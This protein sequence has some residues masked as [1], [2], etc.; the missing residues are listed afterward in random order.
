MSEPT[1]YDGSRFAAETEVTIKFVV[2]PSTNAGDRL[3]T[4]D[5]VQHAPAAQTRAADL[6]HP[7]A[8]LHIMVSEA[9]PRDAWGPGSRSGFFCSP[10]SVLAGGSVGGLLG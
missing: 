1:G 7:C 6:V 10:A 3:P 5:S 2:I 4:A 9:E 8:R